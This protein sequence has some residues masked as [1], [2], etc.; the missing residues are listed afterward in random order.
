M[1][2]VISLKPR[3]FSDQVDEIADRLQD[4]AENFR[5]RRTELIAQLEAA[6]D[7]LAEE[8]MM[9]EDWAIKQAL[10]DDESWRDEEGDLFLPWVRTEIVA[11]EVPDLGTLFRERVEDLR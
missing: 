10:I 2:N 11:E 9:A 8:L 5:K 1:T 4:A 7:E 6:K 3:R